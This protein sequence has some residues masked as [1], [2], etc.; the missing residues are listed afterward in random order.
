MP[1]YLEGT[2]ARKNLYCSVIL[3]EHT[4]HLTVQSHAI[5]QRYLTASR[6][7]KI[8]S[9]ANF[10]NVFLTSSQ[11]EKIFPH[12]VSFRT[13]SCDHFPGYNSNQSL[14]ANSKLSLIP[15]ECSELQ[16]GRTHRTRECLRI[17]GCQRL[18]VWQRKDTCYLGP[19]H[20][21]Q[22]EY[23]TASRTLKNSMWR[24]YKWCTEHYI[25]ITN[26]HSRYGHK[27]EKK[28]ILI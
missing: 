13:F 20:H 21:Q 4:K 16:S 6:N 25:T 19:L 8:H 9:Q 14:L 28:K 22:C 18:S 12:L 26:F 10:K 5:R 27:L 11:F 24:Y 17:A 2:K 15:T 7:T 1:P 23:L 3:Q